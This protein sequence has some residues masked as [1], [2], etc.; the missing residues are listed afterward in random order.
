MAKTMPQPGEELLAWCFTWEGEPR[1][2]QTYASIW[3]WVP[4]GL[5]RYEDLHYWDHPKGLSK[6][7]DY[8]H[9]HLGFT[10]AC[11]VGWSSGRVSEDGTLGCVAITVATKAPKA[12]LAADG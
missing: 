1:K 10:V 6:L 3:I 7:A 12:A 4:I 8:I 2:R 11:T 5:V 9:E